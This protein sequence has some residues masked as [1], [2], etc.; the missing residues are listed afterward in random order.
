MFI[1]TYLVVTKKTFSHA[2]DDFWVSEAKF[3][4]RGGAP[5]GPTP[6]PRSKLC[7]AHPKIVRRH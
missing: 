6:T 3:T 4:A 1:I 5:A 2:T 7:L